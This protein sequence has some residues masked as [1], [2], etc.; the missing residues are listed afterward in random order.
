MEAEPDFPDQPFST[1]LD[2]GTYLD[3]LAAVS[4]SDG[5]E[6][7]TFVRRTAIQA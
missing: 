4:V 5:P 7:T 6:V 1:R 3:V 2:D